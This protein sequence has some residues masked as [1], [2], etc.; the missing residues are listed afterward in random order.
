MEVALVT[1]QARV[2][3]APLRIVAGVA[4]KLTIVGACGGG[5]VTVSLQAIPAIVPTITRPIM[6]HFF[7]SQ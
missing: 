1:F 3:D 2:V 7:I 5:G 6:N 4:V